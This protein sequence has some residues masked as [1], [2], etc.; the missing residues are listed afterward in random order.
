MLVNPR[1]DIKFHTHTKRRRV[2]ARHYYVE[3]RVGDS[4]TPKSTKEVKETENP[5]CWDDKWFLLVHALARC[6]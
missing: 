5:V 1:L 2:L 3:L 6:C 4:N